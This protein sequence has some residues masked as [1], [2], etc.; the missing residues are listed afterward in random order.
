MSSRVDRQSCVVG[1][2]DGR[3]LGYVEYGD[4]NGTPVVNCH[5]GL[6]GRLDIE[7]AAETARQ[8]GVRILS[9]DRPGIG[10]S[11]RLRGRTIGDWASDVGALCDL[12]GLERFAVIGWSFG[13]PYAA[14]VAALLPARTTAGA[15]VA[16]G[17]PF[18]WPVA[19]HG[20]EN[21]TDALLFRLSRRLPPLAWVGMRTTG[22]IAATAPRLWLRLAS[23]ALATRDVEVIERDGL[24]AFGV[25][26]AEGLRRPG[27]AV[28]DYVAYGLPWGFEYEQI[29]VP[30]HVWHGEADG[31]IPKSWSEET[32][33]RIPQAA[34]TVVPDAGH[35]VARD[36]WHEILGGLI[37]AGE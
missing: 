32:A 21:R 16:G 7:P 9:P 18:S 23:S 15:I 5:G 26:I 2:P 27:G 3:S 6:T 34:L 31:F 30:V 11:T 24:A 19:T 29:A 25:S 33:R 37:E 1:L 36:H 14:A 10:R 20:F 4:P 8:L 17:V 28:D 22:A 35:F 13:G 12:L